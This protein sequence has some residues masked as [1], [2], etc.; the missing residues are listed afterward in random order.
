MIRCLSL[1]YF[2]R[3]QNSCV[4]CNL[5]VQTHLYAAHSVTLPASPD[6]Y[7]YAFTQDVERVVMALID[8]WNSTNATV[9]IRWDALPSDIRNGFVYTEQGDSTHI[10]CF[11]IQL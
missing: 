4:L 11:G 9:H 5:S 10:D 6:R 2:C 3:Y 8:I 7:R 1:H